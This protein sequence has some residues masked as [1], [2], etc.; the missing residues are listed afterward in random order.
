MFD[1]W[2]NR[3]RVKKSIEE[4]LGVLGFFKNGFGP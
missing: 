3:K 2:L 4:V 1:N